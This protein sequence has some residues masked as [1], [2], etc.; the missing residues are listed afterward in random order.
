MKNLMIIL[1]FNYGYS[2]A[3][4]ELVIK[5][6]LK[7]A[8]NELYIDS[9]YENSCG[10]RFKL[11]KL[12]FYLSIPL[13]ASSKE[14]DSPEQAARHSFLIDLEKPSSQMLKLAPEL[15]EVVLKEG[16]LRFLVGVDSLVEDAGVF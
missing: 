7:W 12:K 10:E 3:F 16:T 14:I 15:S 9:L 8:K 11:E 2:N 6:D 4:A 13:G 1:F 5:I